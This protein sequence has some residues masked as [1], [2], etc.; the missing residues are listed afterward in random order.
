[1]SDNRFFQHLAG[2]RKGEILV[3][4]K[5]E[6]DDGIVYVCFKDKSRCNE[7]YILPINQK[8]AT[9]KIMAEVESPNNCWQFKDEWVGRQ[10]EVWELNAEQVRVCV[11]PFVAGRK[12]TKL[13]PPR[14][15]VAKFGT[16]AP[17]PQ[18]SSA[19][20]APGQIRQLNI[21][22][23]VFITLERAKKVDTDVDMLITISLPSKNLYK[24]MKESFEE[25]DKKVIEYII[26]NM[27]VKYLKER[28]GDAVLNMYE[29]DVENITA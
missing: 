2:D 19:Y 9:G 6:E 10:E 1:M 22:D 15:S 14:N 7:E 11:Q 23:P 17:L 29:S 5:V 12:V 24:V 18:T 3:F 27:D 26:D 13:I 28:I 20:N 4:D 8:D 25:G 21:S 16:L